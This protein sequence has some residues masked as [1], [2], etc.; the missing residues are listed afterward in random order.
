MA[1]ERRG[2]ANRF[3]LSQSR[4]G[5]YLLLSGFLHLLALVGM[6]LLL[7][8]TMRVPP[9]KERPPLRVSF[10]PA[11]T[12][13][14]PQQAQ[15]LAET[16]SRARTPDGPEHTVAQETETVLPPERVPAG[17]PAPAPPP[18][19][20][21]E[22]QPQTLEAPEAP[23]AETRPAPSQTPPTRTAPAPQRQG[24]G[25]RPAP[26]TPQPQR[27]APE[28]RRPERHARLP[29]PPAES[30]PLRAPL[31]RQPRD[32][33][34]PMESPETDAGQPWIRGRIP[35]LS[36]DDLEK[37]ATL[38]SSDQR[39]PGGHDISLNTQEVKYFSYFAHIKRKIERVWGY[40]PDAIALGAQGHLQLKFVLSRSGQVKTVELLRSSG[41]RAL[42][43]EAWDAVINAGPFDSFPPLIQDDELHITAR[44][45]YVL[46]TA[47]Q[48]TFVR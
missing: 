36:G 11:A 37:Y 29:K 35:L 2:V 20:R 34:P 25:K 22:P 4:V 15:A 12:V 5:R 7:T 13:E 6:S 38:R 48:R 8:P 45:T 18:Q 47:L 42:D 30:T 3:G 44:F 16:S 43:K 39:S 32:P 14:E 21:V 27:T 19:A 28:P 26:V 24:A 40:P 31:S 10:V 9:A 23:K 41:Y 33:S 17:V 46:D 1:R